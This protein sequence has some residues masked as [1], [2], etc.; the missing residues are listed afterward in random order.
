VDRRK[1][2]LLVLEGEVFLLLLL[3]GSI[4]NFHGT[5]TFFPREGSIVFFFRPTAVLIINHQLMFIMCFFLLDVGLGRVV[6]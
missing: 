2:N 1:A 4:V 6:R 5:G 3:L